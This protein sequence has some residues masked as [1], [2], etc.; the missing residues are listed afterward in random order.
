MP[1]TNHHTNYFEIKA[2]SHYNLGLKKGHLFKTNLINSINQE[3]QHKSWTAKLKKSKAY[4]EPSKKVFPQFIEELEG[5]AKGAEVNFDDLWVLS[6]EDELSDTNN[7]TTAITNEGKLIAHNEDWHLNSKD[8]ICILK[9]TIKDL[10]ILEL[11]F[12]NT[13]GG[14]SISINSNGFVQTINTLSH[15][16][17]QIGISHNF[18]ARWLSETKSPQQDYEK[19]TTLQRLAGY[20]HT[21]ISLQ[22]EIWNI[23]SSARK[24]I[25]SNVTSPFV[26]ANHYLTELKKFEKNDNSFGTFDR[27][28]FASKNIKKSMSVGELEIMMSDKSKGPK[29]SI[30]NERTI[31]QMIIDLEN[32]VAYIWLLR[33]AEKGWIEYKIDFLTP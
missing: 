10:T 20:N 32:L 26:H 6:L 16:D 9:K 23:E 8:A 5:Y 33:E 19:L 25:L 21:L 11:F 2:D 15:T 27:Y 24:N 22:G 13:P 4:L 7:C 3:K 18:I 29:A 31:A 14:N 12:Y 28:D 1:G 30:F 17:K